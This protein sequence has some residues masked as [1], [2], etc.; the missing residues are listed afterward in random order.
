MMNERWERRLLRAKK[1]EG[2]VMQDLSIDHE[3]NMVKKNEKLM[4]YFQKDHSVGYANNLDM[5]IASLNVQQHTREAILNSLLNFDDD[6]NYI[7]SFMFGCKMIEYKLSK[8]AV[9]HE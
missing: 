2:E 6:G 4:E 8:K 1:L 3:N 9:E 5:L 7:I